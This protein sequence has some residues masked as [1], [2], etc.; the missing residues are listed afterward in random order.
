MPWALCAG[1]NRGQIIAAK[2]FPRSSLALGREN[3]IASDVPA[4]LK[5]YTRQ[6]ATWMRGD[7]AV[8]TAS[9]VTFYNAPGRT[10][11]EKAGENHLGA[12]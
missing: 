11:G 5:V 9:G 6:V 3:F 2:G 8:F 10:G 12:L 7:M 1:M 4:I